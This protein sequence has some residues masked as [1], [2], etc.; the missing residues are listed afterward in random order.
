MT[1]TKAA[2]ALGRS[3]KRAY[4][5]AKEDNWRIVGTERTGRKGPPSVD[6]DDED[7]KASVRRRA[8]E[9]RAEAERMDPR[10]EK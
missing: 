10:G 4:A 9:L 1:I 3:V 8:E 6:Y 5:I 2:A 7:V